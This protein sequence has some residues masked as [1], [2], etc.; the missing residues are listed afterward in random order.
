[1][2]CTCCGSEM[3]QLLT[4]FFCPSCEGV[5]T[6]PIDTTVENDKNEVFALVGIVDFID[7]DAKGYVT[8]RAICQNTKSVTRVHTH[9]DYFHNM[10]IQAFQ[11]FEYLI[12]LRGRKLYRHTAK[13]LFEYTII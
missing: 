1:M 2:K 13:A 11:T 10:S 12:S 9:A 7:I 8:V 4:S 3:K 6:I 5:I